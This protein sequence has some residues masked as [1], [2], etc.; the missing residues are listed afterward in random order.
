[1]VEFLIRVKQEMSIKIQKESLPVLL[2]LATQ[3]CHLLRKASCPYRKGLPKWDK[4]KSLFL[5]TKVKIYCFSVLMSFFLSLLF[6]ASLIR[7]FS[8][9]NIK[10]AVLRNSRSESAFQFVEICKFFLCF[11]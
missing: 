2:Q 10:A 6:K 11:I 7:K 1:M 4:G 5:S 3:K 8:D 9:F